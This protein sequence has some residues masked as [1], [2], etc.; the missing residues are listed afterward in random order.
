MTEQAM[1]VIHIH[2]PANEPAHK[3]FQDIIIAKGLLTRVSLERM[4]ERAAGRKTDLGQYLER[5]GLLTSREL[6]DV[7]ATQYACRQVADFAKYKYHPALLRT[8]PIEVAVE[9]TVFPLKQDNGRLALAVLDPGAKK[10]LGA[11]EERLSLKIIPFVAT[12]TD[13]NRAI[14]RH[15]MGRQ[16]EDFHAR[17]VLLVEDDSLIRTIVTDI[18]TKHGYTVVAAADGFDAFKQIFTLN[19]KLVI[20]DKV[21]PKLN[22]YEFLKAVRNIPEFRFTPVI[23]MTAN[24]TPDEEQIAFEK[25]FFDLILK[26]IKEIGLMT[27]VRRAFESLENIYGK[28]A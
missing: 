11:I 9:H 6:A 28:S 4:A 3:S 14:A 19:P 22:G 16:F 13:I 27:R 2:N 12:R 17:T 25:G 24:A 15:Y 18:L 5:I 8:I 7:L 23:L 26:P 21:M 10:V 1:S 20:T